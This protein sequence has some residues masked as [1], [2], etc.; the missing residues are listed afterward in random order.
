[1]DIEVKITGEDDQA[2]SSR[3]NRPKRRPDNLSCLSNTA[4]SNELQV[5][6]SRKTNHA[7]Q[8]AS[9]QNYLSITTAFMAYPFKNTASGKIEQFIHTPT[10]PTSDPMLQKDSYVCTLQT[11]TSDSAVAVSV[12]KEK[13]TS[14]D[15]NITRSDSEGCAAN[16]CEVNGKYRGV[17]GPVKQGTQILVTSD[18]RLS[19]AL[20]SE[21]GRRGKTFRRRNVQELVGLNRKCSFSSLASQRSI[22]SNASGMSYLGSVSRVSSSK[23]S[24][25]SL[26]TLDHSLKSFK[27]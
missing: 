5:T 2:P 16:G 24:I 14:G 26:T 18:S 20:G 23:S 19:I 17:D 1:M 13:N 6:A 21:S 11:N 10:T 15:H 7:A 22:N 8:D 25:G 9:P 27:R 4:N 12:G 3:L